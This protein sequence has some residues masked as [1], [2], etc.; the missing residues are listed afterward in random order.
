MPHE[1]GSVVS[2]D[3]WNNDQGTRRFLPM[4]LWRRSKD[5]PRNVVSNSLSALSPFRKDTMGIL[6][7]LGE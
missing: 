5:P 1:S 6:A 3:T 2:N 7:S 4:T